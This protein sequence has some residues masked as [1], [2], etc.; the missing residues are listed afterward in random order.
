MTTGLEAYLDNLASGRP[1]PGGGSASAV[2][3]GLGAA[4]LA[5]VCRLTV[6]RHRYEAYQEEVAA[7]LAQAD[8]ARGEAL[9]LADEDSRAYQAV[10]DALAL[11][12][13]GE[14]ERRARTARVQ[15]ALK[16][17]TAVPLRLMG[18]AAE[19][20]S[21]LERAQGKVNP[22]AAGDLAVGSLLVRAAL[23]GAWVN[24]GANLGLIADGAYV[25][26][27]RA[28]AQDLAGEARPALERVLQ[29]AARAPG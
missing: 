27:T 5:M 14:E 17:A 22:T 15:E 1:T 24:V 3:A 23:E 28:R 7:V 13:G 12:K 20:A 29:A 10:V 11:P 18:L 26:E 25:A 19:L 8:R 6:G 2:S 4:L 16:G 21:L 9:S